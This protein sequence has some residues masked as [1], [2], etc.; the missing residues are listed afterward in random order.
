[1]TTTP[2]ADDGFQPVF[3][4]RED[5]EARRDKQYCSRC[6]ADVAAYLS[7]ATDEREAIRQEHQPAG[8]PAVQYVVPPTAP[9]AAE[10][11][12]TRRSLVRRPEAVGSFAVAVPLGALAGVLLNF[13]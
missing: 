8:Q 11:A 7:A 4:H 9:L 13:V 1:M 12:T 3:C 10:A 5:C 2:R 6:G